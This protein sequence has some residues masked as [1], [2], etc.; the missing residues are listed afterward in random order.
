MQMQTVLCYS[1]IYDMIFITW[2]LVPNINYIYPHS[3]PPHSPFPNQKFWVC[4]ES[5]YIKITK[6]LLNQIGSDT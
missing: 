3:Q 5:H 6:L 4:P 2:Y 1:Y